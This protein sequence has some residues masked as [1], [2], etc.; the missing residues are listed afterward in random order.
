MQLHHI[1]LAK[2][3]RYKVFDSDSPQDR[4]RLGKFI[5]YTITIVRPLYESI[6]GFFQKPDLAWFIHPFLCWAFL[7]TYSFAV[8]NPYKK[9]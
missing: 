3:R 2:I 9:G 4:L 5:L 7:I 6:E 1:S 8:V